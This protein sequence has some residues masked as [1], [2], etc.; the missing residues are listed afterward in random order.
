MNRYKL[1]SCLE[2]NITIS[3][4]NCDFSDRE[5]AIALIAEYFGEDNV[6]PVSNFAQLKLASLCKDLARL[7]NLPAEEVNEYTSKIFKEALAKAK[8]EPGFD[9][10]QWEL[11]L[12][13]AE[14]KS[15]SYREFVKRMEEYPEFSK[16][17]EI[18][19][20]QQRT[21]SRHAGGVII[22]DDAVH[23]MPLIKAKNSL[24]TP[25]SEGLNGRY[26]EELG[27]LKFDILVLGTL[28]MFEKC[29]EK[30]LINHFNIPNPTFKQIQEFYNEHL[31]PDNNNFDD[32]EVYKSVFWNKQY[33]SIFQFVKPNTQNFMKRMKPTCLTDI[34]VATSIFRPG[35]L[36]LDADKLY[37]KNR[38]NRKLVQ[39]VHP[40]VEE[41]LSPTE[42]LMI[43]QE[44]MQLIVNKLAGW[45]LE[46][47]DPI[48]KNFTKKNKDKKEEQERERE[49][50]RKK[51]VDGCVKTSGITE[52]QA[53]IVWND[54]EKWTAYGFNKSLEKDTE[55]TIFDQ[56]GNNLGIKKIEDV[57]S[58][59]FVLSRD[60][61]TKE[62]I[63]VEVA[64]V[65]DHGVI[66]VYEFELDDGTKVTCTMDH[67][68]RVED[69]R[70]LPVW[71]IIKENLEIVTLTK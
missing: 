12:E 34:A 63:T 65:H 55:I 71:Q 31:H 8:E 58:G 51:F 66:D 19:F 47:T 28:R 16:A 13:E 1:H 46:D 54:F 44:Q 43:F 38:E 45:N 35:P 15:P 17:L 2:N 7:W 6:I 22:T 10:T 53:Q 70:M 67:K 5:E 59:D 39:Y 33:A 9:L 68:F 18:L 48:R 36:G 26:L 25:W 56:Q 11:T 29:I 24:Q 62:I 37:L 50:L 32:Q 27:F 40:A 3:S 42:G 30:I 69:G 4:H 49:E 64:K 20:K 21:V 57:V 60:E 52:E 41:V 23:N 14:E 61:Q